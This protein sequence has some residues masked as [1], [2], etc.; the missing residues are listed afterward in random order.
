MVAENSDEGDELRNFRVSGENFSRNSCAP[1]ACDDR[2][3]GTKN[4]SPGRE[5]CT[6]TVCR[7]PPQPSVPQAREGWGDVPTL[8]TPWSQ[9][10]CDRC[11]MFCAVLQKPSPMP[12]PLGSERLPILF[13]SRDPRSSTAEREPRVPRALPRLSFGRVASSSLPQR[14]AAARR[15]SGEQ[16][17]SC[18][19]ASPAAPLPETSSS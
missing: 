8:P 17:R 10:S 2:T 9:G 5:P 1:N 11:E 18:N 16:G 15:R 13:F 6:V 19:E 12:A 3:I 7:S 4:R 14:P